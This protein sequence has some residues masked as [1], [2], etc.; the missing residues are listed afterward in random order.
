MVRPSATEGLGAPVPAG[1]TGRDAETTALFRWVAGL[2]VLVAG[3]FILSRVASPW[4]A[5]KGI[6]VTLNALIVG[7]SA[8]E[9]W[10][11]QSRGRSVRWAKAIPVLVTLTAVVSVWFMRPESALYVL[12]A[13]PLLFI[14]LDVRWAG[15][16]SIGAL[17]ATAVVYRQRWDA[18]YVMLL[19][20]GFSGGGLLLTVW[21]VRRTMDRILDQLRE[22]SR[23]LRETI[24]SV[25]QGV[26]VLD[27]DGVVTLMNGRAATML[28]V[29]PEMQ[30]TR[31]TAE[32]FA[33]LQLARG[34]LVELGESDPRLLAYVS[35]GR[36]VL[37]PGIP[38]R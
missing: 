34:D 6:H 10:W 11:L 28:D 21:L 7:S 33:S 4:T 19:R 14:R 12:M 26:A 3:L 31:F 5:S 30:A 22:T 35:D 27:R 25:A 8:I 15:L 16:V 23:L 13:I 29:P 32:A 24:E 38:E 20:L 9:W 2:Q 1:V 17:S 18:D 36:N 37:A